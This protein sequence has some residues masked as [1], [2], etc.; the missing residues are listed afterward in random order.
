MKYWS[1]IA[2][3]LVLCQMDLLAQEV[4]GT[5]HVFA[6]QV[7]NDPS[8]AEK[9]AVLDTWLR[10][11]DGE[12]ASTRDAETIIIPTVVHVLWSNCEGNISQAQVEDGIKVL[13]DGF[14]LLL[15][16]TAD[17]RE[18]FQPQLGTMNI[19]FRLARID[20]S[21]DPTNGINRRQTTASLN[22]NDGVKSIERWPTDKYFNIWVVE[23]INIGVAGQVNGYAQFPNGNWNTYGVVI[24]NDKFGTIGTSN[25][26]GSTM[27]HEAG[28]CFNLYHTFQDGCG[29]SCASSGDQV[30]DTP[31]ADAPDWS[32]SQ[33][34]NTCSNDAGAGSPYTAGTPDM[35]ENFM[36]YSSCRYA[37]TKG[38][39]ARMKA[40]LNVS[41]LSNL[42]SEANASA[43]GV[44]GFQEANFAV[45]NP[46]VMQDEP[47]YFEDATRYAAD[48]WKWDFGIQHFPST[49]SLQ[50]PEVYFIESGRLPV[51][52]TSY[53]E[54]D[55]L[56]ITK[57][58]IVASQ[59]GRAVPFV[60]GWE[61]GA[62]SLASAYWMFEDS[63]K[64]GVTWQNTNEA[65]YAGDHA[66]M[67]ENFNLCGAPTD[68][69]T[70]TT[71]DLE[72]FAT[73]K[74]GFKVAFAQRISGNNDFLRIWLSKDKG[75]SWDLYW[76][77]GGTGLRSVNELKT[78]S[79]Y[80]TET[81]EWRSFEVNISN[82]YLRKAAMIRLE[83]VG[84]GGNNFFIDDLEMYG[85]YKEKVFL[86]SPENGKLGLPQD[87]SVDW[88]AVEGVDFYEYQ[89]DQEMDFTSPNLISGV[90]TYIDA[91][92]ENDDTE[93]FAEALELDRKYYW[94]VRYSKNGQYS[95]WSD[96]WNFRISAKPL[97]LDARAVG[98]L[99]V[100]PNPSSHETHWQSTYPI[101][102]IQVID[103]QGRRVMQ[104]NGGSNTSGVLDVS[105]LTTGGYILLFERSNQAAEARRLL[106]R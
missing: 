99:S 73:A 97:G 54:G 60:D 78:N 5:D 33:T 52:L 35:M 62:A 64:N 89:L 74:L 3:L 9:Q 106:V 22:A 23:N 80:P 25:A 94:R 45:L 20:P 17:I 63:D 4:C 95:D 55:S 11:F 101:E 21:G 87:L 96:V 19:E 32:C 98:S 88:K 37:F 100:Y 34:T 53:F 38:Q 105:P 10:G 77:R 83:F 1:A 102:R 39:V 36:S 30:C 75:E 15:E 31:P 44:L 28:H 51:T 93:H 47:A 27:T 42:S 66:L 82:S 24:R 49:S 69:M 58:V 14:N 92:P 85:T 90:K 81:N 13:N 72:P 86:K 26:D 6:Q 76:V 12:I 104:V 56:T 18:V 8:L 59:H 71:L 41:T 57:D 46:I 43:R 48:A 103:L 70:S 7:A 29:S 68:V 67:I 16:D 2:A 40:V 61:E 50:N 65:S 91:S 84:D 79:W